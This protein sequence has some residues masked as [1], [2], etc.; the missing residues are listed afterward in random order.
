MMKGNSSRPGVVGNE[1]AETSLL[2]AISSIC[3][4]LG[5]RWPTGAVGFGLGRN[6]PNIIT[7]SIRRRKII[8]WSP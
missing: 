8:T 6:R 2:K 1:S 5:G 3:H 7:T 4:H